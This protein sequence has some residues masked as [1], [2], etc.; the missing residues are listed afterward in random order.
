VPVLTM[1]SWGEFTAFKRMVIERKKQ[2][3]LRGF[4]GLTERMQQK[5]KWVL[6]RRKGRSLNE[7]EKWDP[8][9]R[10]SL[11]AGIRPKNKSRSSEAHESKKKIRKHLHR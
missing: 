7:G 9:K 5:T 6:K 4:F 11:R 10:K 3:G 1:S 8:I 2:S